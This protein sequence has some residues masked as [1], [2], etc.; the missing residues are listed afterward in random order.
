[1]LDG[2]NYFISDSPLLPFGVWLSSSSDWLADKLLFG[3][4]VTLFVV[5]LL[6]AAW[7]SMSKGNSRM[8]AL[9]ALCVCVFACVIVGFGTFTVASASTQTI[10]HVKVINAYDGTHSGAMGCDAFHSFF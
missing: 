6:A 10:E 8:I 3:F 1:M 7:P 9:I 5:L 2:L 4:V